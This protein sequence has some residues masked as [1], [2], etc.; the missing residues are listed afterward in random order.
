MT[1]RNGYP[2]FSISLGVLTW[3]QNPTGRPPKNCNINFPNNASVV[4]GNFVVDNTGCTGTSMPF[5]CF[6]GSFFTSCAALVLEK[7]ANPPSG[8]AWLYT[9]TNFGDRTRELQSRIP[10]EAIGG[11]RRLTTNDTIA[12]IVRYLAHDPFLTPIEI[13]LLATHQ[14]APNSTIYAHSRIDFA[15]ER[16]SRYFRPSLGIII[17]VLVVCC[18]LG[19][20]SKAVM[21]YAKRDDLDFGISSEQVARL[22]TM[23]Y[24]NRRERKAWYLKLHL[25]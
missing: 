2:R 9:S 18:S 24:G 5:D 22:A 12:V 4:S 6:A 23:E 20:A 1:K 13:F 21:M 17:G 3:S 19:L 15:T 8:R 10:Y 25:S 7:N 11:K 14:A 16:D